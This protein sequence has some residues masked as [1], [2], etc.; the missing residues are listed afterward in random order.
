MDVVYTPVS[1]LKKTGDMAVGQVGFHDQKL[2]VKFRVEAKKNEIVKRLEKTK[3][4]REPNLRS[5]IS[6]NQVT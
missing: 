2:V 4:E 1:N 3:Q 6:A 5:A